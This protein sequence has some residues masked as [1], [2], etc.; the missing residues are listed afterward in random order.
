V[1]QSVGSDNYDEVTNAAGVHQEAALVGIN[2]FFFRLA[3]MM[4]GFVMAVIHILSGYKV[5]AAVQSESAQLGIRILVGGIPGICCFL[6][7]FAMFVFYDLKDEK[8]EQLMK[9]L[10]E[11]G[12]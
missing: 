3:W 1:W 8:R 9:S 4:I 6:G 2:N 10:R 5:G 11:K 7:A 12:L